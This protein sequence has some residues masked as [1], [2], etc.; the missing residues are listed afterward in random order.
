MVILFLFK[1]GD[2][3]IYSSNNKQDTFLISNIEFYYRN[4]EHTYNQ[5]ES[6]N[7]ELK[8]GESY[9]F[10]IGN[11]GGIVGWG[12]LTGNVYWTWEKSPMKIMGNEVKDIF[13]VQNS[14]KKP[15]S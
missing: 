1:V 11:E 14:K 6:V 4:I 10:T 7:I 2:S 5:F 9:G 12:D 13:S 8:S 3:L 15:I